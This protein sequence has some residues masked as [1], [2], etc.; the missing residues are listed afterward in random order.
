MPAP[1]LDLGLCVGQRQ[2]PVHVKTLISQTA[3]E[4]F[5][6]GVVGGLAGPA[7]VERDPVLVNPTIER[8]RDELRTVIDA[9][10]SGRSANDSQPGYV[11][12]LLAFDTRWRGTISGAPL[13]LISD[14]DRPTL[15]THPTRRPR[16]DV[17]L[18]EQTAL[19]PCRQVLRSRF[20]QPQEPRRRPAS[21]LPHRNSL[22]STHIRC[23]TTARRLA[24]S[25]M[26]RR[27][28]RRWATRRPD[29]CS[30]D[31]LLP[32][33]SSECAAL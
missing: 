26:A 32:W 6:E 7:E 5:H 19:F 1:R 3:G 11:D 9:D 20:R 4:G 10:R 31:H 2:E 14:K 17:F 25:T 33:V 30:H 12:D 28:P 13:P 27:I 24:T 8:L 23:R 29:A 16:E 21:S 18:P 15:Q 22:P